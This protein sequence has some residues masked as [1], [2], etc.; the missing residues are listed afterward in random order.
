M[1]LPQELVDA[2]L[3]HIGDLSSLKSCSLVA[4]TFAYSARRQIFEKIEISAFPLPSSNSTGRK[5]Y[6]LLS[7]SPHIAPLV[8]DLRIV[9]IQPNKLV[10]NTPPSHEADSREL[11]LVLCY[12]IN[13]TR[14]S[15]LQNGSKLGGK[16][17]STKWD[18][19]E[20]DLKT[21]LVR[22]FSSSRL[23]AVHLRGF[24]IESPRQLLSLFSQAV[25][26]KEMALSRLY[27][28]QY[29]PWPESQPWRPQ[30]RTL[31]VNDN[32][33]SACCPYLMNPQICL[34]HVSTLTLVT[35]SVEL[36]HKM[37]QATG[38]ESLHLTVYDRIECTPDTFGA[39]LRFIHSWSGEILDILGTIFETCPPNSP[40]EHILIDGRIDLQSRNYRNI[41]ATIEATVDRLCALRT[42]EIRTIPEHAILLHNGRRWFKLRYPR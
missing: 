10:E 37:I 40:L 15:L 23:E 27:F 11:S 8:K 19:M 5:F 42:I 30:L 33:S 9:L 2:I 22:V 7:S 29:E 16:F 41:N 21:A 38:V 14:I 24:S 18:S 28:T 36:R 17:R 35:T 34:E 4:T 3:Y 31:L 6:E 13:L 26:L 20:D 1:E 12:L 32:Y 39:N 25:S